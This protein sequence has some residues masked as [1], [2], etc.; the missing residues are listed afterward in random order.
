MKILGSLLLYILPAIYLIA[1]IVCIGLAFDYSGQIDSDWILVLLGLTLPW[2]I[3][4]VLFMWALF[5]GA[6]LEF[7]TVVY[8][9]FAGINA[10]ILNR[11]G[12]AISKRYR[13]SI[14]Q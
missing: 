8:L 5:H 10:V 12:A 7:F 6:G 13:G 11:T 14:G 1:V 2:S 9:L 4:S 3:V